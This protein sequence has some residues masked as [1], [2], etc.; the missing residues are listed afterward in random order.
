MRVPQ[1]AIKEGGQLQ[2]GGGQRDL[3]ALKTARDVGGI[4][5]LRAHCGLLVDYVPPE[6]PVGTP[7]GNA[8]R[9]R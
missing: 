7:F 8:L 5:A 3:Y 1:D 6:E 4:L 9:I 2:E